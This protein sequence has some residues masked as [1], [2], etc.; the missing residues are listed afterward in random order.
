MMRTPAL[1]F[2]CVVFGCGVLQAQSSYRIGLL[3]KFNVNLRLENEWKLNTKLESR[4]LISEGDFGM[5]SNAQYR[6]ALTDLAVVLAKKA[7]AN[8]TLG[9]G[10]M[11]RLEEGRAAHRFIQQYS[12]VRRYTAFR[13]GHRFA[14]DQT[15]RNGEAPTFRFR[16]RIG[17]DIALSGQTVDP[18]EFYVKLNHEYLNAFQGGSYDLEIRLIPFLGYAFTDNNKLETGLDYRLNSFINGSSR[19]SFWIQIGWFISI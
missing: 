7:G 18:R 8:S 16:Y 19:S 11:I 3:P 6:Y 17:M 12:V 10:Y 9:G 1:T 13:L 2:L 15:L 4:Q 14:A 5:P